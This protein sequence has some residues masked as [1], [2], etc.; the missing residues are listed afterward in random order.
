MPVKRATGLHGRALKQTFNVHRVLHV[1]HRN[2][3]YKHATPTKGQLHIPTPAHALTTT[4]TMI[5][6]GNPSEYSARWYHASR[7]RCVTRYMTRYTAGS[8]NVCSNACPH[9]SRNGAGSSISCKTIP[10]SCGRNI[11]KKRITEMS[12]ARTRSGGVFWDPTILFF[13]SQVYAVPHSSLSLT[14]CIIGNVYLTGVIVLIVL[15]VSF[16]SSREKERQ[17]IAAR[18]ASRTLGAGRHPVRKRQQTDR[19]AGLYSTVLY[20]TVC[21]EPRKANDSV[22]FTGYFYCNYE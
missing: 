6:C 4:S 2:G 17:R 5:A 8:F 16:S 13:C 3:T 19:N 15:I 7:D 1:R 10:A 9:L 11:S 20:C 18:T 21:P 22:G 12:R 14:F